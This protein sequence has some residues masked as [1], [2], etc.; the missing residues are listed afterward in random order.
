MSVLVRIPTPMR[1]ITKGQGQV[2][3]ES[4]TLGQLVE[5][6]EESYPG[7]STRLVDENGEMR[8]FV[9]IYLNGQDIR[10]L[11]GLNTSTK[12]GDEVSIVP[13]VA[14]GSRV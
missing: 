3:L 12:S 5:K 4:G 10:F 7:F 6:L 1:R 9:N 13:A 14:G 2:Q 11:Q 8:Y